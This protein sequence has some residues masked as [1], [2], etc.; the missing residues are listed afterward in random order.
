MSNPDLT[1]SGSQ[2]LS[3]WLI[4]EIDRLR[5]AVPRTDTVSVELVA[6]LSFTDTGEGGGQAWFDN[7][8]GRWPVY[9][10]SDRFAIDSKLDGR[11]FVIMLHQGQE[12]LGVLCDQVRILAR[13]DALVAEPLPQ[14]VLGEGTPTR[15]IAVLEDEI[16]LVADPGAVARHLNKQ[17]K[18]H[19]ADAGLAA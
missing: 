8:R 13:Q 10:L 5:L 12:Q 15:N 18:A 11:R 2:S 4:M 1:L 16:I 17:E 14:W 6:D 9:G 3:G 19:G 7:K